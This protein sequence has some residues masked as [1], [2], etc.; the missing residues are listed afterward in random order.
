MTLPDG[1][2]DY[3]IVLA[4][5]SPVFVAWI[6]TRGQKKSRG[7]IEQVREHVVNS[8]STNLRDDLDAIH[9]DIRGIR[10]D[11]GDLR[12]ETREIR[13]YMTDFETVVRAFMRLNGPH[14][15]S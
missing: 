1:A 14:E 10:T 7:D 12:D 5:L 2:S 3:L 15:S 4:I 13:T 8:H 9:R 11:V 6:T